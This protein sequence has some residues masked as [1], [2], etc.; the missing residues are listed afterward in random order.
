MSNSANAKKQNNG[1][2]SPANE[3]RFRPGSSGNQKGR[4]P[5]SRN[6][7]TQFTQQLLEADAPSIAR[8]LVEYA[9]N[10]DGTALKIYFDRVCPVLRSQ[11]I[12]IDL[13]GEINTPEDA[14]VASNKV[15]AAMFSGDITPED[16]ARAQSAIKGPIETIELCDL[17]TQLD[18]LREEI[19][20]I[21][22]EYYKDGQL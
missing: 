5:G 4:P 18:E 13:P 2:Q 3:G 6:R 9:K 12:T 15:I 8:K 20:P 22:E 17:K 1:D 21:I 11:P 19:T 7:T 10:G 14:R 16:A